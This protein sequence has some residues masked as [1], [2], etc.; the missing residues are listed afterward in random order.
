PQI[1]EV[2][3]VY[4]EIATEAFDINKG[5]YKVKNKFLFT[6]ISSFICRWQVEAQGDILASGELDKFEC[7]PLSET[8]I[9]IPYNITSF[10]DDKEVVLTVSF[11]TRK[12]TPGLKSNYEVAWDQFILNPMPQPA[13]PVSEGNLEFSVKG[14]KVEI[15]GDGYCVKIDNGR[16][17]GISI[18][19]REKLKAPLEP[20]Y[21]RALTDNDIDSLNFVPQLIPFH[22]YYKWRTASHKAKAVK[23]VVKAGDDNCVEIHTAWKTPM[24]KNSVSTYK[25]YPDKRIYVYFSAIPKANMIK[26]GAR[27]TLDGKMEYVN[28]YGRGPHATYS[29]RKS[30]AKISCHKSTVTELEHRYMRPQESSNRAD[31]RCLTITDKNGFGFK[32][33]SYFN[34]FINFSAHHYTI[35]QLAKTKHVH[36]IPYNN[37][38]TA[39]NIDH[40]QIGVGGDL[41]G[42]AFVREP[43]LMKKGVKQSYSFV[44]EPVKL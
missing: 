43:Y 21:F 25:V 1:Y 30:G 22:P 14:N 36:E 4:A 32:I 10:P 2:K 40:Q 15:N 3:K 24:L 26:F 35:E 41:P 23:T 11:F 12:K 38:I 37:E 20:Y 5:T 27:M 28:W 17:I 6:D 8:Y 16:I 29:D 44:I 39:L 34:D 18:D 7:P 9:N 31:V 13:A 33:S 42:Q 19:G